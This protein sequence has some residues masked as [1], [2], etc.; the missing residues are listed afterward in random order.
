V[1]P[2]DGAADPTPR[3]RPEVWAG[4]ECTVR[5][6]GDSYLDQ[7]ALTGH[8][9]RLDDLDRVAGLGIRTVRYPVLWERT[10]PDGLAR[11]D[12]SWP[13]ERLGRLRELGIDPIVGLVH[14]G[15]GP[16]DTSLLDDSFAHGLAAFA[17]AVAERY[18]WVRRFTPVNEPLT[19]ARLSGLYGNWYPH[20]RDEAT[21][22]RALVVQCRATIMAMRAIREVIP[23]ALLVQTEDVGRAYAT[24]ALAYQATFENERRWLSFDLLCGR[25]DDDHPLRGHLAWA[26][27]PDGDV[28]WFLEHPCPP[29][30]LGVNHYLSGDRF[31][32]E[33]LE[34]YPEGSHGGNGR[35]RYA[36]VLAARVCTAGP[37]GPEAILRD[38]WQRYRRPIAVTE[39]HNGCTREEQLR[40]FREVWDA[41]VELRREGVDVR[42]VTAWSLLG[43]YDW[44][45]LLTREEGGYEAGVFDLRGPRPRATALAGMLRALTAGREPEHPVLTAPGW[46]RRPDRLWYEPSDVSTGGPGDT[47]GG[48]GSTTARPILITGGG[49]LARAFARSCLRRGLR[50]C[51]LAEDLLDIT[52]HD[53]VERTLAATRPWAVVNTARY[54]WVDDAEGDPAACFR[55]NVE[56]P[57]VLAAACAE[58]GIRLVTFSSGQVFDGARDEPYL[59]QHAAAPLNVFGLAHAEAERCVLARH[60]DA[61]VVRAG[62]LFGHDD[63]ASFASRIVRALARLEEVRAPIDLVVSPTFVPDLVEAVLDLVI[64]GE[65]GIRHLASDGEVTWHEF[66]AMTAAEASWDA[67]VIVPCEIGELNFRAARP[68]YCALASER[69]QLLPTLES[70]VW[71]FARR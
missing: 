31:L 70:A 14:H 53:T 35:H 54:G 66:A 45:S 63:P 3:S 21:F 49:P 62:S 56:G 58:R 44:S 20:G 10:A 18:G 43:A 28:R 65:R 46:W 2:P 55:A 33:R 42:A 60:P 22:M 25:V 40:W 8:D 48:A 32:D 47:Y 61:M 17:R 41:A 13:D 12:W 16:R 69:A 19:T 51:T 15:S 9:H 6:L 30:V 52:D 57:R 38:V 59:E 24:P 36:D 71:R 68:A 26:G 37:A 67:G 39:V 50:Q 1:T 4:F 5:R 29:D 34:R 27:V 7:L 11:A 64:D 23:D